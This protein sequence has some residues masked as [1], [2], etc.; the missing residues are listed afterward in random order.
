MKVLPATEEHIKIATALV[1]TGGIVV[2]PT[3]TV[4]GL[5]CA[6]QINDAARRICE[7]KGRG[8]KPLPLACS[9][10]TV[11]RKVVEFNPI[12]ERL[13]E[14]FWPGPLMLV[15]PAVMEYGMYVTHGAKTLGVRVPDH[16]VSRS[17]A[18]QSGGVIV[19][20]SANK[21]GIAPPTTVEG[22]IQ[23][24]GEEV[25]LVLDAGPTPGAIP[26]T[27]LN[28]SGEQIW[29]IRRGPITQSQI[30]TALDA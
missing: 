30:N 23:Q 7:I 21:T 27:V 18:R 22:A 5:G 13:A 28:L 6:P 20:T 1:R 25:D 24:I 9:S 12:A 11:A 17:L 15:L 3:E 14:R 2:Y 8:K 4:Y 26:S 16:E 29:V 10:V 19:S